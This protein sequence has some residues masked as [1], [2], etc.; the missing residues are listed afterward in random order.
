MGDLISREAA[1]AAID[2]HERMARR[3]GIKDGEM[4]PTLK[5]VREFVRA[6][7]AVDAEPVRH[8]RWVAEDDMLPPEYHGKKRC[9]ICAQFALHDLY[10]R[11]RLSLYCPNSGV[12]MDGDDDE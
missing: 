9:S 10:G 8:G 4:R 6:L 11:E 7:P 1:V 12:K 3:D 5:A 2:A